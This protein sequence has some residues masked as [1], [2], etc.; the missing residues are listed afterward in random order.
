MKEYNVINGLNLVVQ[1]IPT[2]KMKS[3]IVYYH[4]PRDPIFFISSQICCSQCSL[5]PIRKEIG[6]D[7]ALETLQ[8]FYTISTFLKQFMLGVS[9]YL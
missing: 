8:K 7:R 3:L 5:V 9:D 6:I 4:L 1:K 2:V